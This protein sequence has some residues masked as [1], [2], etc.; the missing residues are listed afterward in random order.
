MQRKLL[1]YK[2]N[3]LIQLASF[4]LLMVLLLASAQVYATEGNKLVILNWSE[5]LDPEVIADFEK[6]TGATVTEIYY[7]TDEMRNDMLVQSNGAGYDLVVSNGTN[8]GKYAKR[9][10]LTP[11][12]EVNIPN[13]KLVDGRWR[14][15]F[16]ATAEYAVPFMWGTLGIAYRSDKVKS[17]VTSWLDLFE[18]ADELRGKIVMIKDSRDLVGMALKAVGASVNT[19][20]KEE[21]NA[22]KD[23]LLKQKPF[24]LDYSYVSLSEDA[25]LVTGEAWMAMVYNGDALMLQ[26]HEPAIAFV[27]PKEGGNLWC[28]Y[29]LVMKSSKRKALAYRFLEY[30]H[31][32]EIMARLA[33][34]AYYAT[35]NSAAEK[36]LPA[37]FLADPIIYPN[38]EVLEKSETYDVL[39]PRTKKKYN[40]IF[41]LIIQ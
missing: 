15:A 2:P 5:Y 4:I 41:N 9:G 13:L 3:L 30:I 39:A 14:N 20:N 18:P 24:V 33:Q 34:F 23:L 10:W 40:S 19:M 31:R 12:T 29:F 16:P 1:L 27:Q 21:L 7:E 38:K 17:P 11:V 28:D 32:P 37:E 8:V 36:L 6:E 22:A 26:E 35:T 25:T